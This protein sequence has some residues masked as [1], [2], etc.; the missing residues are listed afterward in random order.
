MW[1]A[2]TG[3]RPTEGW[4]YVISNPAWPGHVKIGSAQDLRHRLKD[5]NTGSPF[6]D[7]VVAAAAIFKDRRAAEREL[8]RQVQGLRVGKTEWFSMH[9]QDARNHLIRLTKEMDQ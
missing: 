6:R 3:Q 7:F 5:F 4:V 9:P 8:H 1:L 2:K